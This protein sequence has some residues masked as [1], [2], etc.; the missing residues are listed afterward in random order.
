MEV[1]HRCPGSIESGTR[2]EVVEDARINDEWHTTGY[3]LAE[4][5]L[6]S[7]RITDTNA[8]ICYAN[9][10]DTHGGICT[11]LRDHRRR[12]RPA[13]AALQRRPPRRRRRLGAAFLRL[14]VALRGILPTDAALLFHTRLTGAARTWLERGPADA[15]LEEAI[16]RFRKRFGAGDACR[17][18]LM[19]EF[20]DEKTCRYTENKVRLVRRMRVQTNSSWYRAP[21]IQ[22]MRADV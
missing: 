7:E 21:T 11:Y 10:H 1:R 18:E 9:N 6:E 17:S 14:Y 15:P 4:N 5:I 22:G 20:L 16:A 13:A 12:Q 8:T 3:G 2:R 19:T